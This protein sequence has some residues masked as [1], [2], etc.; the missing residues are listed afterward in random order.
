VL[1]A[2][3]KADELMAIMPLA[4]AMSLK[5]AAWT[6]SFIGNG[7]DPEHL[8]EEVVVF[9]EHVL[10]GNYLRV[11]KFLP[12]EEAIKAFRKPVLIVHSDTDELVP[13]HYAQELAKAYENATLVKIEGDNHVFEKEIDTVTEA[14]VG[15]LGKNE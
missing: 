4:P 5:E 6:G 9:D 14:I 13:Y 2:A 1:A 3:L 7:F 8:P 15:F 12:F 11:N 10:S